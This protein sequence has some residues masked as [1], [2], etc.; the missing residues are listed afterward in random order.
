[1]FRRGEVSRIVCEE[2]EKPTPSA[3]EKKRPFFPEDIINSDIRF[4]FGLLS[5][6]P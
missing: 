4:H 3:A 1:M 5:F 2:A 6:G